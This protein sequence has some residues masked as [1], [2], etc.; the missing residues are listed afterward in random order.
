MNPLLLQSR[1]R[2]FNQGVTGLMVYVEGVFGNHTEGRFLQ[3]LEGTKEDVI[4]IY[5]SILKDPRHSQATIIKEGPIEDRNFSSWQMGFKSFNI[6]QF[7]D[8]RY[9]FEINTWNMI[10]SDDHHPMLRFLKSFSVAG[11]NLR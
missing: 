4:A 6:E 2:N 8:L 1:L 9:F 10:D 11:K 7:P 5:A 3:V